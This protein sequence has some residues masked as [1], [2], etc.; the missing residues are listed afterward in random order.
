MFELF[1]KSTSACDIERR[2]KVT[3]I[4]NMAMAK[5][6]LQ[7]ML[8]LVSATSAGAFCSNR[9]AC[10]SCLEAWWD[11]HTDCGWCELSLP[12]VPYDMNSTQNMYNSCWRLPAPSEAVEVTGGGPSYPLEGSG[13]DGPLLFGTAYLQEPERRPMP[14][15]TTMMPPA[16]PTTGLHR[17]MLICIKG[18]SYYAKYRD[19][20][21]QYYMDIC[22]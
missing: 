11:S 19:L 5:H 10:G 4:T 2:A 13:A 16:F 21:P 20:L 18:T 12:C 6:A 7:A 9:K 22:I 1:Y 15:T 14:A 17:T 8:L 3:K